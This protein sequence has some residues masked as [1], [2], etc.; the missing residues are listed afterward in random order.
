MLAVSGCAYVWRIDELKPIDAPGIDS[1]I[2]APVCSGGTFFMDDFS[3]T[4]PCAPWGQPINASGSDTIVQGGGT[5]TISRSTGPGVTY[6][7]STSP[8][9]FDARGIFLAIDQPLTTSNA[10]TIFT[11]AAMSDLSQD[12][13]SMSISA[14]GLLEFAANGAA[15]GTMPYGQA[16]MRYVRLRND[17]GTA[18]VGEYSGDAASWTE[19]GRDQR[20]APVSV[21]T[22]ISADEQADPTTADAAK[23]SHFNVCP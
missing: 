7:E 12:H 6:C 23:F 4:Q 18:I 11:V 5:L 1:A 8:T 10:I 13:W 22:A 2:D 14:G 17:Q 21:Y 3:S 9:A 20:A 15:H 19:L 16:T